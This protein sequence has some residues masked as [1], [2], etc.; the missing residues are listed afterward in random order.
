MA[1]A[2]EGKEGHSAAGSCKASCAIAATRWWAAAASRS[3]GRDQRGVCF[4]LEADGAAG[5]QR[6]G[7]DFFAYQRVAQ[8]KRDSEDVA[9]GF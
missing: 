2:I 8:T 9:I 1:S 6:T 3:D 7:I 5:V 4:A